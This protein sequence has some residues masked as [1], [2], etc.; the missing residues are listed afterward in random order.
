LK[1]IIGEPD[2]EENNDKQQQIEKQQDKS[3]FSPSFTLKSRRRK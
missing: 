2:I 3:D 1:G